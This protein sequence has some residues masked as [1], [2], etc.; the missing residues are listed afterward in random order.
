LSV[1]MPTSRQAVLVA[2]GEAGRGVP[3][4]RARVDFAQEALGARPV[5]GDDGV[6]MLRAVPGD[7]L[8][9]LVE[10]FTTRIDTIGASHSVYSLSRLRFLPLEFN[11]WVCESPRI[12]TFLL[13]K[14]V[15]IL[16]S[17]LGAIDSATSSVSIVLQVP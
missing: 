7:V 15:P 12:S 5:P 8:D 14:M 9:R 10:A 6:G 16:G 11:F 4:H 3:H 17:T 13:L 2:V 1:E